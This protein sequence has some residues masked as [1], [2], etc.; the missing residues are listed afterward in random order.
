M[1]VTDKKYM[2]E[3]KYLKKLNLMIKRLK[4]TDDVVLPIDGDEGQ[5]K[6]ELAVGTCYYVAYKTGRKYGIEN[7]FFELDKVI[8]FAAST[9]EQIIHFDE[10]AFGLLATN[11]QNKLHKKFIQLVMVSRKKKHFI[12]LCIPKF[13]R[14]PPYV[15]EERAI[16][17]VH[18]YSRNNIHKGRFCYFN[19]KMKDR[20]YED[21]RRT[22]IKN[23][24]KYN[25][26]KRSFVRA[27]EKVF[28]KKQLQEYDDKKD[29]AIMRLSEDDDKS[30]QQKRWVKQRDYLI[31]FIREKMNLK[32]TEMA[33]EFKKFGL[34]DLTMENIRRAYRSVST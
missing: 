28:T 8:K 31:K 11:W 18:V 21:W 20:L 25:I 24:K 17:L 1:I 12:I 27:M 3:D 2:I 5:G 14:L 16:G 7:I 10:A 6:T 13:H 34:D 32:F 22:K 19:K 15:I 23:Y 33:K 26:F 30:S 9:K 4:G 29:E